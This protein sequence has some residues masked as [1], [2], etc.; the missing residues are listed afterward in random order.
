[1]P[2]KCDKVAETNHR[3]VD[4]STII[5]NRSP[6]IFGTQDSRPL[7]RVEAQ[8]DTIGMKKY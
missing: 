7:Y 4:A 5:E 1:M 6:S 3:D 8:P 2:R